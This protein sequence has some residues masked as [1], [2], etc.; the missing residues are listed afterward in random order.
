VCVPKTDKITELFEI[1]LVFPLSTL[2]HF[3]SRDDF[4]E[5][6]FDAVVSVALPVKEAG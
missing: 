6:V 3:A 4:V 1:I 2:G 5:I